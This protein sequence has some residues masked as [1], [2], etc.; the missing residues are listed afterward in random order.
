MII[1]NIV[2]TSLAAVAIAIIA[3]P[4]MSQVKGSR[5]LKF[6]YRPALQ[7]DIGYARSYLHNA[8]VVLDN[9][10]VCYRENQRST[11]IPTFSLSGTIPV[12]SGNDFRIAF[13]FSEYATLYDHY[14]SRGQL[15]V[16][17]DRFPFWSI[18]A[19]YAIE[20]FDTNYFDISF[21]S[22]AVWDIYADDH[23]FQIQRNNFSYKGSLEVE[24]K[25]SR[26]GSVLLNLFLKHAISK[27]NQIKFNK[28]YYPFNYGIEI[29]FKR[30]IGKLRVKSNNPLN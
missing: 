27:Y 14:N 2:K 23:I 22:K 13:G 30:Y 25:W 16:T 26:N 4:G 6:E 5:N 9:C 28:D 18:E 1:G 15:F 7:L 29:A 17:P 3:F 10:T 19:G 8:L 12:R 11:P 21:V 24:F 20:L